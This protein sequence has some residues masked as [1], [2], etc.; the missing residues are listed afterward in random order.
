MRNRYEACQYENLWWRHISLELLAS[1]S[2]GE[3]LTALHGE[4][5]LCF[6]TLLY[7]RC[8]WG[9]T[10]SVGGGGVAG[11]CV[12]DLEVGDMVLL[13]FRIPGYLVHVF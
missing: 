5:L 7:F 13:Q 11:Y 6:T 8:G 4:K 12:Q 3:V 2:V 9:S 1:S 10:F